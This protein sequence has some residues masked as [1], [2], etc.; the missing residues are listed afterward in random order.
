MSEVFS[1]LAVVASKPSTV[2][3][4]SFDF[5]PVWV[6]KCFLRASLLCN[7]MYQAFTR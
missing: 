7:F 6:C 4:I 1:L 3:H 2:F 5:Y